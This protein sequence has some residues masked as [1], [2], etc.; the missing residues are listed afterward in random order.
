MAKY[1]LVYHG[2]KMPESQE[3]GERVMAAWGA[4]FQNMGD[5]VSDPG[6]PVGMSSTVHGD[7]SVSE[8]GGPNPVSGYS[9]VIADSIDAALALAKSCPILEDNGSVEVAE[10]MEM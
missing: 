10:T 7:G 6:A 3:E 1:L 8:D 5:A 2:G 4:W 9:L